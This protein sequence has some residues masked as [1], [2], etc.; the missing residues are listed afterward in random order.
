MDIL[1][2]LIS[3]H[4]SSLISTLTESGFTQEQASQFLPKAGQGIVNALSSG[5]LTSTLGGGSGDVAAAILGKL[6]IAGLASMVGIDSS[7]ASNGLTAL[8]PKLLDLV[9]S[10]GGG[11]SSLLGGDALSTAAGLA[12]KLFK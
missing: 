1:N 3:K 4:S 6:D 2:D 5:D 7:L 12:S 8:I 10:E 9:H 11:L